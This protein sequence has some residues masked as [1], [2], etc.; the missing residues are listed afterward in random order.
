MLA[1]G[2]AGALRGQEGDG[3]VPIFDGSLTGW[4]IENSDAG[5]FTVADGILRVAA[6]GGWLRSAR[7]YG[8]VTVRAE[9]RFATPDADSG[10]F[11]R[12]RSMGGFGR[13]WPL[14]S[15]QV[16]M[17]NPATASRFPPVG[18]LFRHGTPA[19]ETIFDPSVAEKL[20]RPTGEWQTLEAD[21]I[22][23]TLVARLNG[24][25]VLKAGGIANPAGYIGLQGETGAVEFRSLAVRAR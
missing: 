4:T 5:N 1:I 14:N 6:P 8:D 23:A 19:G 7:E 18:G 13:G 20:S 16:Q 2:A 3:F 22:G 10:L 21:V 12:A 15:Y 9:F 11:V 24:T 17:R 25:E